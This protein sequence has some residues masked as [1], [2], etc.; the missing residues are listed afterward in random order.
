MLKRLL[1]VT[2]FFVVT[3]DAFGQTAQLTHA[4]ALHRT[5]EVSSAV[6]E[7]LASAA[8]VAASSHRGGYTHV[9][10]ADG[11]EG[12]VYSR[13]LSDANGTFTASSTTTTTLGVGALK[14]IGLLEK[15]TPIEADDPACANIGGNSSQRLDEETNLLKNRVHDGNYTEVSFQSVLGLPWQGMPTKRWLWS[16]DDEKRTKDYEGAAVSV[17]GYLVGVEPKTG[18]ACNCEKDTPD[19]VDWHIWLVETKAEAEAPKGQQKLNAIVVETTPRVRKEFSTRFDLDQIRTWVNNHDRVTVSGWLMLDPDHPT[20]ATGT[21][22]K[23]A[24]R[25]TIWEIHPVTK[26]A[27]AQ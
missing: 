12:W 1:M 6:I 23:R 17:T 21:A 14:D 26:I 19:W 27:P 4:A 9:R 16:P 10:A 5:W 22:K 2:G 15:P 18:E 11:R 3:R 7:H 25:G 20:D 8:I 13:Y 24:S